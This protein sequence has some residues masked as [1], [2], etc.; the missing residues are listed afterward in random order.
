MNFLGRVFTLIIMVSSVLFFVA[1]LLANA[2]HIDYRTK[3]GQLKTENEQLKAAINQARSANEEMQTRL[4]HE[5]TARAA[6]LASLQSQLDIQSTQLAS[7]NRTLS[8]SN[9]INTMRNQEHSATLD[10]LATTKAQND[11]LRVEIDKVITD[12][13]AG[14]LNL[15]A[16]TDELNSL[17]SVEADLRDQLR[18]L[19]D[20]AT[21]YEA[22]AEVRGEALKGFGVSDVQDHPPV[23][24]QGEILAVSNGSSVEVSLGRDDGI[25][26]GHTLEVF[27]GAQYLGRIEITRAQDD[28]AVGKVLAAYRKGYIQAGDKVA[29][30]IH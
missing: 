29:S 7:A 8:E 12:R 18:Q 9:A 11:A 16:L 20:Q 28:K 13:N 6:A 21:R 23:D 22:L 30:K 19:Q 15:I 5:Q 2:S 4:S 14:R 26:V 1:A 10:L 24:L 27:R 3:L 25:R 17:K